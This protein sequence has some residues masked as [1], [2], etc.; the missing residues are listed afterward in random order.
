M[1]KLRVLITRQEIAAK[2]AELGDRVTA[3]FSGEPVLLIGVLLP[4]QRAKGSR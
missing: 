1:D 2:V 4:S 3:D